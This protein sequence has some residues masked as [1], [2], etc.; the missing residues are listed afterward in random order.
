MSTICPTSKRRRRV[1]F[2]AALFVGAF[3][4][5]NDAFSFAQETPP[6]PN[7][8]AP[9][10]AKK[11]VLT[12]LEAICE[13]TPRDDGDAI[14]V[15]LDGGGSIS[16][17]KLDVLFVGDSREAVFEFQKSRTRL[18]DANELLKLADW[19]N[20]R[21]LG[22]QGIALLESALA[23]TTDPAERRAFERKLTELRE[24]EKFR[25]QTARTLAERADAPENVAPAANESVPTPADS[26]FAL[27]TDFAATNENGAPPNDVE[28]ENWAKQVPFAALERFARK[29]QPALQKRCA[30][31]HDGSNPAADGYVLRPK[32]L[33]PA[34]RTALLR[35]LRE[36]LDFVDFNAPDQSPILRHPTVVD[37]NGRR[38]YPFGEDRTSAKDRDLFVDW[39]LTINDG[40]F[41]RYVHSPSR[42]RAAA[43]IV[44]N[45]VSAAPNGSNPP[46]NAAAPTSFSNLFDDESALP[47]ASGPSANDDVIRLG[48][49]DAARN[50][51]PPN[52]DPN[53]AN[54]VLERVGAIPSQTFRDEYD[55][56]I[57]NA[58]FHPNAAERRE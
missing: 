20:R 23:E 26:S 55:P 51:V 46:Q 56:A 33:G 1:A 39:V 24:S 14:R 12:R 13:G 4:V 8:A 5:W 45:V 18:D 30:A 28:L 6:P 10:A 35:N 31:C 38:V 37:A 44:P 25:A 49:T 42:V 40:K 36:T 11:Y 43:P 53:S 22:P 52:D 15:Q 17:S 41:G 19:A 58:R 47:A 29:A 2:F 32:T 48:T 7:A 57:F 27:G 54:A 9:Q 21:R 16:V 50:F 34:A 3:A